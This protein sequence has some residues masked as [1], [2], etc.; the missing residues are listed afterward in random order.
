M[1]EPAETLAAAVEAA[2]PGWVERSVARV[3]AVSGRVMDDDLRSAARA[4]GARARTEVGAAVRALLARDIDEQRTNPLSLL[5]G[6]VRYPTEV[7]RDAGVAV[8]AE[9]D[10]FAQRAFPDDI[11]DLTPATWAD[12]D[13]ALQDP[14][15]TW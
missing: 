2:L 7:L 1:D 13:P 11:Y 6:A 14:G 5:R 3:V 15:I 4:A 9:R 8:V 12:I 10:E